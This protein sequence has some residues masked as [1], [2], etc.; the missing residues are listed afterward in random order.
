M[1]KNV[2]KAI[3]AD[4]DELAKLFNDYRVFYEKHSDLEGAKRF[5]HERIIK[6]EAEI[7][8]A[9]SGQVM[10][11]FVLLY[12]LFSSTRMKRLWLLNDLFVQEKYRGLG[13]SI[14]LMERS[15]ELCWESGACG[16]MLETAKT[17]TIANRLYQKF[18]LELDTEHN[19][20]NWETPI[21]DAVALPF[22]PGMVSTDSVD[23]LEGKS[24][25]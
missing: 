16:F 18:G 13:F 2:R 23:R 14:A 4:L 25:Y 19:I 6:N 21:A 12:P 15:K 3:I 1:G 5:L 22:L 20:Y 24:E 10:A 11:G 9:F 8:V 17:N 7:F